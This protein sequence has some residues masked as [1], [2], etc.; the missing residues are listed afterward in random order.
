[1]RYVE[2]GYFYSVASMS[3]A[4]KPYGQKQSDSPYKLFGE[5][6]SRSPYGTCVGG[7]ALTRCRLVRR[8]D[9]VDGGLCPTEIR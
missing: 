4:G 2:D 8:V 9:Q 7:M 3:R 6:P 1:M 5:Q